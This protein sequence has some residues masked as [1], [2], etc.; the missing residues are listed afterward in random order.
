VTLLKHTS[1]GT[2]LHMREHFTKVL[3]PLETE[4][5]GFKGNINKDEDSYLNLLVMT[6]LFRYLNN[7][8]PPYIFQLKYM[9]FYIPPRVHIRDVDLHRPAT[10]GR[11]PVELSNS[12]ARIHIST[13]RVCRYG[14][15]NKYIYIHKWICTQVY[16]Y[17]DAHTYMH[18]VHK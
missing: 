18:Q 9:R 11:R 12:G 2:S 14:D 1:H 17:E 5:T 15:T 6:S 16:K 3:I 8:K 4:M 7:H 10:S 13:Q